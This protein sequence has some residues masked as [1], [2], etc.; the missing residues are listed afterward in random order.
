MDPLSK[1]N[2]RRSPVFSTKGICASSQPLASA[3]GIKILNA[4][5]NAADAACAIAAALNVTEPC[6]TGIG[7]DAFALYYDAKTKKVS[8]LMGNGATSKDYSL[9]YLSKKG[10]SETSPLPPHSA[11]CVTVPGSA[12]LWEDLMTQ[13]G[14]KKCS[15][16]DILTPAI[17]LAE[18]GFPVSPVT[19]KQWSN[20][21]LQGEEGMKIFKPNGRTPEA[22]E[23]F[24]NPDLALTFRSLA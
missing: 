17:D 9:K 1:F 24:K 5:G 21:T 15:F 19:A 18:N 10:Y 8:C 7:G 6:S 22:G 13:Y 2:S 12:A 11:L 16:L 4:G 23:L 20:G 14:S 3:A